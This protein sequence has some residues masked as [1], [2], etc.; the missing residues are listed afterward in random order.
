M[1]TVYDVEL[2]QNDTDNVSFVLKEN[3]I[4]A[5]L[6]NTIVMFSMVDDAANEYNITCL[7][8]AI[9]SGVSVS[10]NVGGTTVPFTSTHTENGGILKGKFLVT[11]GN[12]QQSF[13]SGNV[14][15]SVRI[16]EAIQ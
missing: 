11:R 3:G 14:Y 4:G 8:G 1:T 2:V 15:V 16:W 13:P 7:P 9:I 12:Y 5:D 10:Q 6:T